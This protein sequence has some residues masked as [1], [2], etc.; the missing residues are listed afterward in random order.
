[1]MDVKTKCVWDLIKEGVP[2]SAAEEWYE[3]I[4][5]NAGLSEMSR[6]LVKGILKISDS[7]LM[8]LLTIYGE[9]G[10]VVALDAMVKYFSRFYG[11]TKV[12]PVVKS[13]QCGVMACDM[14]LSAS[15]DT[16]IE[17][18]CRLNDI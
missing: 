18:T 17:H 6:E 14:M 7:D 9:E 8:D 11:I 3:T 5:L 4:Y 16:A 10:S 12:L 1:M 2:E 15:E 13:S